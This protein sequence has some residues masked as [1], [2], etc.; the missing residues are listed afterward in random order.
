MLTD[1][2]II[3]RECVFST[4]LE[5]IPNVRKDT[6]VVKE[7]R[8]HADGS[9][10]R[11]IKIVEDFKRPFW[12]TKPHF[13]NHKQKKEAEDIDKLN[14]YSSTQSDLGRNVAVRLG[15]RYIGRSQLRDVVDNPFIYGIDVDSKVF[16]KKMYDQKFPGY[17]TSLKV[18][19]LD[20][21]V[22]TI[23]N[24][25]V[26]VS[27]STA[28]NIYTVFLNKII[29]NR[30]N[31][32]EQFDF[33]FKKY[34]PKTALTEN[35]K[36]EYEGCETEIEMIRKVFAK[37]HSWQPDLLSVWNLGYD[38]GYILEICKDNNVDPKDIF[39]DPS[40]PENLRFFKLKLGK[41]AK[42]TESGKYKP[43]GPE[44]TWHVVTA[45]ASFYIMDAMAAYNY[46]RVGG[47]KVPGG[48]G[49]DNVL[50]KELG[51]EFKKLKFDVEEANSLHGI[52]WHKYML[53]RYPL[54]YIIYN[55]WDTLS[56]HQLDAKT[57]DLNTNVSTLS[58][59]SGFDVFNSGP[60]KIVDSMHF[61][62]VD[63]GKVL[64]CR[65]SRVDDDKLLGLDA[66]INKEYYTAA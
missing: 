27:V 34:V 10:S 40:L 12:I 53:S 45:P 61:F 3:A 66:W 14:E 43:N 36:I 49:L 47:K 19:T 11:G 59:Y 62:Y 42:V 16:I 64:G 48:Y 63:R 41:D 7:I 6:H 33:L 15:S 54:M 38:L 22:N 21:E 44:E 5:A 31:L 55:Q 35:V 17:H 24:E 13:Q 60:K 8:H 46:V 9:I 37:L 57:K 58:G 32:D 56:M 25:T 20:I 30:R 2:K 51:E 52:D 39:S 50:S 28:D 65:S 29:P 18:A 23:T 4:H 26:I 1:N